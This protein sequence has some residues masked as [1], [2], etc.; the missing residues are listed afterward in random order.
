MDVEVTFEDPKVYAKPIKIPVEATLQAD[1]DLIEYVC[2]ENERSRP[3][4]IGT[5]DDD[6]KLQVTVHADV[7]ARYAGTFRFPPFVPGD[8][9]FL[10]T[11]TPKDGV[12]AIEIERGPTHHRA[13]D[14]ADEVPGT[15][16]GRRVHSRTRKAS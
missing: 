5:A 1:T 12:L 14:V 11:V 10:V 2:N 4:L 15:G 3:R 9:P 13:A 8:K 16:R 7:L 6:K